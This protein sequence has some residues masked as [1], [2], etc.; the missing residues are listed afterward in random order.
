ML[1]AF[2]DAI[3]EDEE[4][5]LMSPTNPQQ[6]EGQQSARAALDEKEAPPRPG[7]LSAWLDTPLRQGWKE[8]RRQGISVGLWAVW[9]VSLVFRE[10]GDGALLHKTPCIQALTLTRQ[11]ICI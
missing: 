10:T 7:R 4:H 5:G 8:T 6:G 2:Q 9:I 1:I 11:T 3:A